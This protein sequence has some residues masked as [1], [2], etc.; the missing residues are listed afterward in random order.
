MQTSI[1]LAR[2]TTHSLFFLNIT[3]HTVRSSQSITSDS[4]IVLNFV[5]F[6]T[7]FLH[8]IRF[9]M[10]P[11]RKKNSPPSAGGQEEAMADYAGCLEQKLYDT[12]QH[13]LEGVCHGERTG[14]GRHLSLPTGGHENQESQDEGSSDP[15]VGDRAVAVALFGV[16]SI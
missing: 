6:W 5:Y 3:L 14:G 8:G 9:S 13:R 12:D 15:Q 7:E 10:S 2:H 4:I 1:S 16:Q 11:G